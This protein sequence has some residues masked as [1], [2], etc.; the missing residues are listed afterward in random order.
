MGDEPEMKYNIQNIKTISGIIYSRTA[1]FFPFLIIG[2]LWEVSSRFGFINTNL[3]SSPSAIMQHGYDLLFKNKVLLSHIMGSLYR[4]ASGYGLALVAGL[5]LGMILGS[6]RVLRNVF[7]PVLTYLL[8][9]PT[10]AWVPLLLITLGLGD[11]TV[12]A[13]VFLGGFFEIT[14]CTL[15]AVRAVPKELILA[16]KTMGAS[17]LTVW[18]KVLIPGILITMFPAFKLSLGYC[19]RALVGGEMLAATIK[20]GLGKMIYEARFWND[21]N[22]MFV[23][24]IV[25][26]ILGLLMEKLLITKIENKTLGRWGITTENS[27]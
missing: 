8:A 1:I 5:T 24:L 6:S 16:S 14:L 21:V 15:A 11:T 17:W 27:S 23:G 19:W 20:V 3:L 25:I 4:L 9:V 18:L 7:S 22:T 10:I 2:I 26:G 12:I 13:A